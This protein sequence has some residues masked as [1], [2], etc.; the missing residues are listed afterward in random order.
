MDKEQLDRI[1][2][3][4]DMLLNFLGVEGAA[5]LPSEIRREAQAKVLQLNRKRLNMKGHVSENEE[6]K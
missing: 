1:E 5:R 4:L 3:K 6:R 2:K